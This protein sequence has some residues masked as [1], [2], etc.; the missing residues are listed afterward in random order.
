MPK[1]VQD[2][3]QVK[4]N[5]SGTDQFIREFMSKYTDKPVNRE[6]MTQVYRRYGKNP[7]NIIKG[8]YESYAPEKYS[9]DRAEKLKSDYSMKEDEP[10]MVEDILKEKPTFREY[11]KLGFELPQD[12]EEKIAASFQ[13]FSPRG[14]IKNAITVPI[15]VPTP[16]NIKANNVGPA[17][18]IILRILALNNKRGMAKG[19]R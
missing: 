2:I 11:T 5:P 19:T 16:P 17:S 12:V 1:P 3:T 7:D 9:Q 14:I 10:S 6:E 18:F 15:A 13:A 8:L 4:Y